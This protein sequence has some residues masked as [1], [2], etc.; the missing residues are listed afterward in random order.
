VTAQNPLEHISLFEDGFKNVVMV[1][2]GG[3]VVKDMI[4]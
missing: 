2:K 1:I 3:D 4:S